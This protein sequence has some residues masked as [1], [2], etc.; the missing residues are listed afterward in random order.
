MIS[1]VKIRNIVVRYNKSQPSDSQIYDFDKIMTQ[2][3][4]LGVP[5][6]KEK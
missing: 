5:A 6:K 4:T 2:D 3:M 1:L